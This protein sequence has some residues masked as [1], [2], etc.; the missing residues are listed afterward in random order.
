MECNGKSTDNFNKTTNLRNL[1]ELDAKNKQKKSKHCGTEN[2]S[3]E[4]GFNY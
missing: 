2:A 3:N 1:H 4:Y